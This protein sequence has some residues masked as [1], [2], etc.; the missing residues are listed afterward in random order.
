MDVGQ[1][2]SAG[3]GDSSQQLVELLVVSDGQL[4][5]AGSD[6]GTLVVAS[7][8]SGQLENLSGEVLQDGGQVDWRAAS[9]ASS[10]A[11]LAEETGHLQQNK[12]EGS[13]GDCEQARK[14][15]QWSGE[16]WGEGAGQRCS[17]VC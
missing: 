13:K 17:G 12:T 7:G 5:V 9:N 16:Q 14:R 2:T 4:N 10:I 3:D 1:H 8:V 11:T 6:T 15:E